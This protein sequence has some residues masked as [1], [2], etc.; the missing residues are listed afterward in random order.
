MGKSSKFETRDRFCQTRGPKDRIQYGYPSKVVG[1]I[2]GVLG[3]EEKIRQEVI[4]KIAVPASPQRKFSKRCN[5][6]VIPGASNVR[7][8]S[9]VQ[10]VK[11]AEASVGC[12]VKELPSR[13]R[14]RAPILL[15]DASRKHSY[16]TLRRCGVR[17]SAKVMPLRL[18]VL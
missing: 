18:I 15:T 17:I 14:K 3:G 1:E 16:P 12:T 11:R 8:C 4:Y 9:I 5:A 10:H 6:A 2:E 13:C 7:Y